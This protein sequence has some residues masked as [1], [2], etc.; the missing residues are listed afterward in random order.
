[1]TATPR[2]S[3]T[4]LRG[5]TGR[6]H[7]KDDIMHIEPGVVDGAKMALAYTTAAGAAG[8]TAKLAWDELRRAGAGAF[9]RTG[10]RILRAGSLVLNQSSHEVTMDG[11][12]LAITPTEFRLLKALLERQ[13]KT[14]S[15]QQLLERAW[16][17]DSVVADRIQT[18]TVDM[19]VR[20]LRAKL[21]VM[22]DWIETV[23]GMGYRFKRLDK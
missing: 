2:L 12:E 16:D 19:H 10:A 21:G 13:G 9:A 15:R 7:G 20:R 1:M 6:A 11:E 3:G 22:G 4:Y 14:Q 17:L 23:R 5:R 8:Y 18:R